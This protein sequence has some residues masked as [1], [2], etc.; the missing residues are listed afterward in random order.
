MP[1]GR[2]D[3]KEGR[4]EH[5]GTTSCGKQRKVKGY[6]VNQILIKGP[7]CLR[8]RGSRALSCSLPGC[9]L[10]LSSESGGQYIGVQVYRNAERSSVGPITARSPWSQ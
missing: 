5:D 1:L 3:K 9:N 2:Q 7:L 8:G 6:T 4:A 10:G